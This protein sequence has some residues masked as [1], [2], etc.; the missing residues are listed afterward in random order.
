[1][2]TS[3]NSLDPIL[4]FLQGVEP[5]YWAIAGGILFFLILIP[6]I[7]RSVK[8]SKANK[9]KP[10]LVLHNFQISPLGKDA[11]LRLRNEGQLAILKEMKFKKRNDIQ[12]KTN[13]REVKI[14]QGN[15][16][17][18]FLHGTGQERIREDFEV[19][20]LYSDAQ[21]HLYKQV[22]KLDGKVMQKA[23]LL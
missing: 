18:L 5:V 10:I 13:F 14:G 17:S 3:D 2:E 8:K 23:K 6:I 9:L 19:E 15:T 22:L 21:G 16:T 7:L 20:F 4:L 1:M 12:P 11:W